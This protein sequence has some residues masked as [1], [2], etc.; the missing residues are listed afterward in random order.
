[1]LDANRCQGSELRVSKI[2]LQIINLSYI[3]DLRTPEFPGE[4]EAGVLSKV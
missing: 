3:F 4:D 2:N 1:M